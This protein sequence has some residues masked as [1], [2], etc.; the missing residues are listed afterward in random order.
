MQHS[1]TSH[2]SLINTF[3]LTKSLTTLVNSLMVLL[4]TSVLSFS[5]EN[6]KTCQFH[7]LLERLFEFI[8]PLLAYTKIDFNLQSTSV[9][10]RRGL[11]LHLLSNRR[12]RKNKM[13]LCRYHSLEDLCILN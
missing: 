6:L 2:L 5:Q 3:A 12:S 7:S 8:E 9:S 13:N 11:S 4:I 1:R 10:T